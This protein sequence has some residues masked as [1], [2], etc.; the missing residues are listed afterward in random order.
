MGR[1]YGLHKTQ[2][3]MQKDMLLD[4]W[5]KQKAEALAKGRPDLIEKYRFPLEWGYRRID[6]HTA[7]MQRELEAL[8]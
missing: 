1:G 7:A 3:A 8:K 5:E 6:K 4:I 2:T